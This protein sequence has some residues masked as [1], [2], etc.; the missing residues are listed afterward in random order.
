MIIGFSNEISAQANFNDS[1]ITT[2]LSEIKKDSIKSTIQSLQNFSSRYALLP[3]R[4]DIANWI[5]NKFISIGYLNTEIDSFKTKFNT[6]DSIWQYNIIASLNSSINKDNIIVV[7]AHYDCTSETPKTFAPGADDNASGVAATIEVARVL[8]NKNYQPVST[9]QFVAFAFEEGPAQGSKYFIK[10]SEAQNKNIEYMINNDMI[11]NSPSN[12]NWTVSIQ[13]YENSGWL[14]FLARMITKKYTTLKS[15]ESATLINGS[16]SWLFYE[17]GYPAIYFTENKFSPFWHKTSDSISNCNISYCTEITKITCGILLVNHKNVTT[18]YAD[19]LNNQ[20]EIKWDNLNISG[21]KGYNLYK[22]NFPDSN[23]IKVNSTL[24]LDTFFIDTNTSNIFNYYAVTAVDSNSIE[25]IMS[26][27]DSVIVCHHNQGILIVDD[28]RSELLNPSDSIVDNFYNNLLLGYQTANL[29]IETNPNICLSLIG[30]YNL[31]LW[32]TDKYTI[33][34]K[35]NSYKN[36][37][38]K[39]LNSGGKLLLTTDKFL[40]TTELNFSYPFT[41]KPNNFIYDFCKID[42][43]NRYTASRFIGARPIN[44]FYPQLNIDTLKTPTNNMHHLSTIDAIFNCESANVIYSYN[45][46]Y[47]STTASGSMKGL[48]VGIEFSNNNYKVIALSFPLWYINFNDAKAFID[49][50]VQNVFDD[51]EN[52]E[53]VVDDKLVLKI[54]NKYPNPSNSDITIEYYMP[55][56][57]NINISLYDLTGKIVSTITNKVQNK[58]AYSIKLKREKLKSGM[59]FCKFS[60][61]FSIITEKIIFVN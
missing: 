45:S 38:S 31:I 22:S 59:Y 43:V 34:S 15:I 54:T 18:L 37:L 52:N 53:N 9:I 8:K 24:L 51:L 21:I 20:I 11:A 23:F 29:D 25:G 12:D 3:N 61:N 7:G 32:H 26:N 47:D 48:P 17:K 57:S 36:I 42:S 28:S 49:Y 44:S 55:K 40:A 30:K 58:G 14:T 50:V 10:H 2:V 4:I 16:D 41:Y 39:F 6:T 33:Y 35:F 13:N 5:K 1:L 46:L 19:Y 56:T 60:T 27:C